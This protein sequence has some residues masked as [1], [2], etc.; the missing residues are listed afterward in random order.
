MVRDVSIYRTTSVALCKG[1]RRVAAFSYNGELALG[2]VQAA[3]PQRLADGGRELIWKG[4]YGSV[5]VDDIC[6]AADVSKGSVIT[7]SLPRLTS[8]SRRV[9]KVRGS[10]GLSTRRS[11]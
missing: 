3:T 4:S 8:S 2:Y 7:S 11:F 10:A 6:R 1:S 5:S 9:N